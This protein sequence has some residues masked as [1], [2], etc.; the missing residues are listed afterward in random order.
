MKLYV[1][2]A[3]FALVATTTL[4]VNLRQ[5][6]PDTIITLGAPTEG[7]IKIITA[8][9]TIIEED[10][11]VLNAFQLENNTEC[12]IEDKPYYE[13]CKALQRCDLCSAS[14]NCGWNDVE[15]ACLPGEL[16]I[17]SCPSNCIGTWIFKK[18]SCKSNI[19][20]GSLSNI[21]ADSNGLIQPE[22]AEEKK[23]FLQPLE[24]SEQ[25]LVGN[26]VEVNS[27]LAHDAST[28][29]ADVNTIQQ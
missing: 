26:V 14:P 9:G 18:A 29:D 24:Q 11:D 19:K 20:S 6:T 1:T 13:T 8:D 17:C 2:L 25:V 12:A 4:A 21:A 22:Y 10:E 23:M 5:D 27:V 28:E 15:Q 7:K 3:I 16:S